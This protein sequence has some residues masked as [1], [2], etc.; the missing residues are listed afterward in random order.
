MRVA[1]RPAD[2]VVADGEERARRAARARLRGPGSPRPDALSGREPRRRRR[3]GS[4]RRRAQ[5]GRARRGASARSAT[6]TSGAVP[7]RIAARDG[8]ARRIGQ[9][10]DDLRRAGHEQADEQERPE[11]GRGRRRRR[12]ATRDAASTAT[13][14]ATAATTTAP[15][16]GSPPRPSAART[17]T[18]SSAEAE[19]GEHAEEDRE[20]VLGSRTV[21]GQD[22]RRRH[23]ES[24]RRPC[25]GC[26]AGLASGWNVANTGAVAQQLATAYGVGLATVGLF[27]TALFVTHLRCRS[28][29]GGRATASARGAS[30]LVGLVRH[31]RASTRSR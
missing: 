26:A 8:P 15:A 13:N 18:A 3:R 7:I 5:G 16:S 20:H 2:E 1:R 9:D 11:L 24:A 12:R 19:T 6:E 29:P 31:R 21:G 10:E 25:G 17:A 27:T 28:R 23:A 22:R 30:A 14:A 4:C